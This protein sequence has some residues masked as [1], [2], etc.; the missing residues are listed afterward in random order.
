MILSWYK[1]IY[2]NILIL[3]TTLQKDLEIVNLQ[4][5]LFQNTFNLVSRKQL[6]IMYLDIG[7]KIFTSQ[8]RLS[9]ETDKVCSHIYW[10]DGS[11]LNIV[12]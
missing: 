5:Q 6:T 3:Q 7:R 4:I 11:F 10:I 8:E 12:Y 1:Q 9:R 2:E